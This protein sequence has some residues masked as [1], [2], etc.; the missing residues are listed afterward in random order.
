MVGVLPQEKYSMELQIRAVGLAV[1]EDLR[2]FIAQRAA[3]LD[4]LIDRVVDAQ[5]ELRTMHQRTGGDMTTAQFTLQ[6]RR[7]ILRSEERDHDP[8]RA[9]DQAIDKMIRQIRKYH[10]KRT[11]RH[12]PRL[13]GSG[14]SF[15]DQ[16][17]PDS[18][19]DGVVRLKRFS[20]KPMGAEE[21]IDQ[22]ELLGH[23]FY[24]FL[25]ADEDQLNVLY[26]RRDGDYGL[27]APERR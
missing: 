3:K 14:Q 16:D 13:D 20:V 26:R 18:A 8:S 9:V 6:T 22:M 25:N 2:G 17:E 12:A 15:T 24:L 10:D 21:A 1:T 7:H 23:D 19:T 5:L 4:H 11:D 27:L